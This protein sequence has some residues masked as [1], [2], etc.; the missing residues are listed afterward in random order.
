M[1]IPR[2]EFPQPQ[3]QR[4]Q[5]RNLNGWWQFAFDFGNSGLDREFYRTGEFPEQIQ[6]PFCPESELSGLNFHDFMPAVWYQQTL[7][8]TAAELQQVVRLHFGAVDYEC[9]VFINGQEVGQHRGGYAPFYFDI[10]DYVQAGTNRLTVYAADDPRSGRQPVGKQSRFYY[11][12][13]CDY[14]RTTGIWQTVWLEFMPQQHL[15]AVQFYP[16]IAGQ[17]V[18]LK[19]QAVGQG[20]VQAEISYQGRLCGTGELTLLNGT[21]ILTIPLAELHLWE[22]GHGRLYDVSLTYGVDQVQSYFGMREVSLT[23]YQFRLNKRPV[24]QRFVLDQGFYPQGIYTAPT[25]ADL[26]RDIALGQAAGFNGARL[27]EKAFEPRYLYHCD[28][29]G[30][31]V[32]GEMANWGLDFSDA[33]ATTDFLPE[34]QT[35][36]AR[37]FN[38]PAIVTWCPFNETWDYQARPQRPELLKLLYQV[39]KSIDPTRPCIDTSGNYHVITDIY[40]VHDYAQDPAVLKAHFSGPQT[41]G[42]FWDEH[43]A[44]QHY[45]L[46]QPF[47]VSEFGGIKWPEAK[48]AAAKKAWGYGDTPQDVPA[49][50]ARYRGLVE[51]LLQHPK[52]LGF[53][54]T[55]LY[56]VE[57]EQNGL[58][59][60]E[61]QPKLDLAIIKAINQQAAAIEQESMPQ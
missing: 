30:Y 42:E 56:D 7:E 10:N 2:P 11:S 53:C 48:P 4:S 19:I 15:Q 36:L 6:V 58:C 8:F 27:H 39:T 24:F 32:W 12:R 1:T 59:T 52:M 45:Q 34:W 50:I 21:G 29:A 49:F 35:I 26:K 54:Y 43:D 23:G 14:T 47:C 55:Q 31:L 41:N 3:F 51:V 57:Q 17:Q 9:R 60:Y 5:W 16:N 20:T 25:D 40:D 33:R 22:V 37:D 18:A 46:G 13:G 44:R 38:H 61:R 28:Q